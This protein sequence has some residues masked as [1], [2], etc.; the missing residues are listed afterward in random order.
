MEKM[1][2][3]FMDGGV[4][5]G[6]EKEKLEKIWN[7]W[8]AF[9]KYAFNK[10]HATCYAWVGYQ[11]GY[12]KAHYAPE[13][14]AANLS[15]NLND[16]AEITNLMSDCKR[17]G[18]KV[19]GPDINESDT[20]FTANAKGDIRFGLGGI[21]GVGSNA[22]DA[23][24]KEREAHGNFKDVFDFIERIPLTMVNRKNLENLV[25]AGAFDS[26]PEMNRAQFFLQ[27]GKENIFI[28]S[29]L[30][31]GQRMQNDTL[32][33]SNSLFG[34]M[35]EM[36]PVK[37]VIPPPVEFNKLEMLKKEKELVGMYLSAH[38]LDN[39]SFE[40][41]NLTTC[42]L[43]TLREVNDNCN[44]DPS[45]QNKEFYVAGLVTD[46]KTS[47]TRKGNKLMCRFTVEDFTSDFTFVLFGK[48]YENYIA[49]LKDNEALLVHCAVTQRMFF[50]KDAAAPSDEK[51]AP[52]TYEVKIRKI[53]LLSN[54]AD[55]M[56]REM[57]LNIP[58]SRLNQAFRTSL[59]KALKHQAKGNTE[60]V[61]RVIEDIAKDK[62][63][64]VTAEF[65]CGKLRI[66]PTAETVAYLESIPLRY[67][68]RIVRNR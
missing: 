34:S 55:D 24:I 37:P 8:L 62:K 7:D 49:Y 65:T 43:Q 18:I 3:M 29:L 12:L 31:Y 14:M 16:I 53:T 9:A 58:V 21:K 40:M 28:D 11:T 44:S 63:K 10:S 36:K 52:A 39:F 48:D 42:T 30:Q 13:F 50:K 23:I 19:L 59:V 4:A 22:I 32:S 47:Y 41:A 38:P 61:L 25:Y 57:I 56:V 33:S 60:V 26:F 2:S 5:N 6:I 46:V 51:P 20:R 64:A 1:N 66:R 67:A 27:S 45:L 35:D 68:F 17:L 15:K 54:A